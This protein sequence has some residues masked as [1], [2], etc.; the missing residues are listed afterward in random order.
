MKFK[1][2]FLLYNLLLVQIYCIAWT[3][4]QLFEYQLAVNIYLIV[5][6]IE[7]IKYTILHLNNILVALNG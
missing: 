1:I 6:K 2:G 5:L 7:R 3:N 4:Q